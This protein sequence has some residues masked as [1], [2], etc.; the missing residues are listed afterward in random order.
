M[1]LAISNIA[2]EPEYNDEVML[3]L[4][5][6]Q[7][8]LETT[9]SKANWNE[10]TPIAMQSLIYENEDLVTG[11]EMAAIVAKEKNIKTLVLGAARHKNEFKNNFGALFRNFAQ[12][13]R[14]TYLAI[15]PVT[16]LY[17]G[18]VLS[19]VR[20]IEPLLSQINC[21]NV[22]LCMDSE[23][24]RLTGYDMYPILS[25]S[26]KHIHIAPKFHS[27]DWDWS[28]INH[29]ISN[30]HSSSARATDIISIEMFSKDFLSVCRAIKQAKKELHK[31][32]N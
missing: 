26:I 24:F 5:K 32:I 20:A 19:T 21:Y 17:G 23:N 11:L 15:E 27:E 18:D 13:Y 16:P 7:I 2:W 9:R 12:I 1:K 30:M 10:S 8:L 28:Y 29:F 14:D 22:G 31:W 3:F 6:E 25:K 4:K